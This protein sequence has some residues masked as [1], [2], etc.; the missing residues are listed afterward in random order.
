MMLLFS[1]L[2][3]TIIIIIVA[4][5]ALERVWT[6]NVSII[7]WFKKP[8]QNISLKPKKKNISSII[9]KS[10]GLK[11]KEKLSD[12]QY[13]FDIKFTIANSGQNDAAKFK[14]LIKRGRFKEFEMETN[15]ILAPYAVSQNQDIANLTNVSSNFLLNYP[16]CILFVE[17][18]DVKSN[19][20]YGKTF[21]RKIFHEKDKNI[22]GMNL[23]FLTNEE[24]CEIVKL[25]Y[26]NKKEYI[27]NNKIFR[28]TLG[29]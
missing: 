14:Y 3:F 21:F 20:R 7:E 10:S 29:L 2:S 27:D 1:R 24:E 15:R 28:G 23:S 4:Y 22:I 5:F 12:G 6:K 13:N 8:S 18:F 19:K 26:Q 17:W 16:Y 25:L 9:L 11:H